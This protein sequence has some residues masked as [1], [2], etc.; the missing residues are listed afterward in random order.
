MSRARFWE[1]GSNNGVAFICLFVCSFLYFYI[2][3]EQLNRKKNKKQPH[4]QHM[5]LNWAQYMPT[6]HK[7]KAGGG[8]A[9]AEM[10]AEEKQLGV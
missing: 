5:Q 6:D 10:D 4:E 7:I 2:K 9:Q 1:D 3:T 8:K